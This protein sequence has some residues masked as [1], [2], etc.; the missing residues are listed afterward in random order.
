[1][2]RRSAS[3]AG[4]GQPREPA[5]TPQAHDGSLVAGRRPDRA[6]T[7][8][9]CRQAVGDR[10]GHRAEAMDG[11]ARAH[12]LTCR[13]SAWSVAPQ[14][15][16][17]YEY[18][19][20]FI[21]AH[22]YG[23]NFATAAAVSG[24]KSYPERICAVMGCRSGSPG[25]AYRAAAAHAGRPGGKQFAAPGMGRHQWPWAIRFRSRAGCGQGM[26]RSLP[27][28][29][30][31]SYPAASPSTVNFHSRASRRGRLAQAVP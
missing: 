9:R 16:R 15:Q 28:A 29:S 4:P 25:L 8:R 3:G 14:A 30:A 17:D 5:D 13:G 12:R 22:W 23:A 20:D 31:E 19:A 7:V 27:L 10:P 11:L 26:S 24:L 6:A 1:V 2:I 21:T 18:R